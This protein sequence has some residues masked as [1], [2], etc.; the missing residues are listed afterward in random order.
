M[1]CKWSINPTSNPNPVYSATHTH[2]NTVAYLLK[3]R[4]VE[5]EKQPLLVN[6]SETFVSRQQLSK[7]IPVAMDTHANNSGTV[8]NGVFYSVCAK[9]L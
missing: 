5:E 2:D 7:H 9:G 6:S 3:G 1:V 8:G 4:T